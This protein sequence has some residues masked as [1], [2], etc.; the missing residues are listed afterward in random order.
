[1]LPVTALVLL[2]TA[3]LAIA[4][5]IPK[6]DPAPLC[7]EGEKATPGTFQSCM[8]DEKKAQS[9]LVRLWKTF[10]PGSRAKCLRLETN[11]P[12]IQ[13]YVELLT[14]VQMYQDAKDLPK[15]K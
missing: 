12:G 9:D 7:R 5:E 8:A 15:K 3:A 4:Q 13:S 1:V 14:C 2:F 6:L 10:S 11:T